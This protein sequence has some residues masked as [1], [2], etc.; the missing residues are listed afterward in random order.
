MILLFHIFISALVLCMSFFPVIIVKPSILEKISG[1]LGIVG[2]VIVG[3]G[4]YIGQGES[5]NSYI[6][7]TLFIELTCLCILTLLYYLSKKRVNTLIS[8]I[9]IVT[10]VFSLGTYVYYVIF[11]FIEY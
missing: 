1:I 6:Y 10:S 7:I 5:L 9:T 11:S 4:M 2:I 3:T 8:V